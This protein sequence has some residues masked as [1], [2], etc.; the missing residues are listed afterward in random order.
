MAKPK[1]PRNKKTNV[2]SAR[3]IAKTKANREYVDQVAAVERAH[4]AEEANQKMARAARLVGRPPMEFDQKIADR[5]CDL[6]A[7]TP[8]STY[9]ILE[10]HDDLPS[11]S[12]VRKWRNNYPDFELAY[13]RAK[14]DQMDLLAEETLDIA[15]TQHIGVKFKENHFGVEK[16]TGDMT[17]HRKIRIDTRKWLASK[18]GKKKYGDK[19]HL[20]GGLNN[21]INERDPDSLTDEQLEEIAKRNRKEIP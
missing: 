2:R 14:E 13:T 6:V 10:A 5:I 17:E 15:D 11:Y 12:T 20:E 21:T 16:I 7:S 9:S 8:K 1:K 3:A 4:M 19:L 18:L